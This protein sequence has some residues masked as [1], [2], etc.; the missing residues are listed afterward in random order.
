MMIW[1]PMGFFLQY[2]KWTLGGNGH[3]FDVWWCVSAERP[4]EAGPEPGGV[5]GPAGG[6][7]LA[8]ARGQDAGELM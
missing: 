4:E 7:G 3:G 1:G 8:A 2:L 5:R 6:S